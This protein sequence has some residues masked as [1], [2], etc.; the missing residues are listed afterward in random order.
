VLLQVE[1]CS[2]HHQREYHG[3]GGDV[4]QHFASEAIDQNGGQE[5]GAEVDNTD[6]NCACVAIEGAA[7]SL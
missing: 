6:D 4:Q 3:H 2:Q 1:E 7:S 5:R